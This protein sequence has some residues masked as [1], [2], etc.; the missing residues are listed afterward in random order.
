MHDL[1]DVIDGPGFEKDDS[2]E[3]HQVARYEAMVPPPPV[4]IYAIV[5]NSLAL[6][7][8]VLL[9]HLC[10]AMLFAV[11]DIP[12]I[13]RS[14]LNFSVIISLGAFGLIAVLGFP[15]LV[16]ASARAWRGDP[17]AFRR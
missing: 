10:G 5:W 13:A 14:V 2:P 15:V 8:I 9:A 16:S 12:A 3:P 7:V 1:D 11:D 17:A 6:N 4:P